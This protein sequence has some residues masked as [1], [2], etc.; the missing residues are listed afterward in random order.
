MALTSANH[1][2]QQLIVHGMREDMPVALI[3]RGTTVEQKVYTSSLSKLPDLIN[4]QEIHAPTLMIVGEVVN[5]REKLGWF[6]D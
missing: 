2:C 6:G 5:L 3:E 1:V 4:N